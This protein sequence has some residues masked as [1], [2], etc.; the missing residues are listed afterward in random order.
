MKVFIVLAAIAALASEYHEIH[1]TSI[2]I[3][4]YLPYH[5]NKKVSYDHRKSLSTKY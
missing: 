3:L 5:T 2:I 4:T 1:N